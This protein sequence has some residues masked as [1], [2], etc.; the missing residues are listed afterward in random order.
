M[1]GTN[2]RLLSGG[3]S[4][5]LEDSFGSTTDGHM[6]SVTVSYQPAAD[7][8]VAKVRTAAIAAS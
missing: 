4:I 1:I 7:I 8:E 6:L 2:L 5:R 3:E